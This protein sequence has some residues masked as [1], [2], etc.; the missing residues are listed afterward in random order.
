VVFY[1]N[2][3]VFGLVVVFPVRLSAWF[4]LGGWFLYQLVEA[5][6]GLFS[7][8]QDESGAVAFFA[9]VGGFVFGLVAAL[10]LSRRL[11]RRTAPIDGVVARRSSPP[12]GAS[13][14]GGRGPW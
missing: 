9:H 13:N 1:P 14:G 12:A 3:K 6:V 4:F 11:S 7:T 2:S 8:A 10:L 5:N